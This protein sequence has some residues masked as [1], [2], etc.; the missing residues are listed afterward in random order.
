MAEDERKEKVTDDEAPDSDK[1][2][3][4]VSETVVRHDPTP[5]GTRFPYQV[6]LAAAIRA[7][8]AKRVFEVCSNAYRAYE[9]LN[10]AKIDYNKSAVRLENLDTITKTER[11]RIQEEYAEIDRSSRRARTLFEFELD[12]DIA[13]LIADRKEHEVRA[14]R[15]D[16][17]LNP[18][19]QL[20]APDPIRAGFEEL[21]LYAE[22]EREID[23]AWD[24]EVEEAGGEENVSP[25]TRRRFTLMRDLLVNEMERRARRE[26]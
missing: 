24:R 7:W 14:M 9:E 13:R 11:L 20:P 21:K 17:E 26:E 16:R 10:D 4:D 5:P 8:G 12:A 1:K 18:L 19:P 22:Y 15:H 6:N 2:T 3:E 23:E 25:T